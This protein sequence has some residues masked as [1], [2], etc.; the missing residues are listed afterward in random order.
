M[1]RNT[2][3]K[4]ESAH[5]NPASNVSWSIGLYRLKN[6]VIFAFQLNIFN[7]RWTSPSEVL[8][9]IICISKMKFAKEMSQQK[10]TQS[11]KG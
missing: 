7:R 11:K 9:V 6:I 2:V 8:D 1:W 10:C 5:L 3:L 4:K